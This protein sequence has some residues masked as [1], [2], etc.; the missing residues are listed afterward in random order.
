MVYVGSFRWVWVFRSV[1]STPQWSVVGWASPAHITTPTPQKQDTT[2]SEPTDD[3]SP[4]TPPKSHPQPNLGERVPAGVRA[5]IVV[6]LAAFPP[7]LR[8]EWDGLR[9]HDVLFLL[10][11][12]DP[13]RF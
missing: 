1:A 2:N 6:D 4:Q 5:E 10:S 13:V 8:A 9:E 7:H 12:A 3:R 11:I